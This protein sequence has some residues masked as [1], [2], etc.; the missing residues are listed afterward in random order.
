MCN[1]VKNSIWFP[2][3]TQLEGLFQSLPQS[4]LSLY[5]YGKYGLKDS[6]SIL[7]QMREIA[8]K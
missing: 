8:H 2:G 5:G 6:K 1:I 4:H 7:I 3:I